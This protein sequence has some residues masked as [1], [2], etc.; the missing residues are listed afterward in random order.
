MWIL[1]VTRLVHS[2]VWL[3]KSHKLFLIRRQFG[4]KPL[5][6]RK[7]LGKSGPQ[8]MQQMWT[9]E[10]LE[11]STLHLNRISFLGTCWA[12]WPCTFFILELQTQNRTCPRTAS[13]FSG[14]EKGPELRE[15]Q[16]NALSCS[17]PPI[18]VPM[19][20]YR[21]FKWEIC[22]PVQPLIIFPKTHFSRHKGTT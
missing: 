2:I 7:S 9:C 10:W 22:Y 1:R 21:C 16:R 15:R 20:C 17:S 14:L 8:C 13:R 19:R 6:R 11:S 5:K 3:S 4:T 12:S 18:L